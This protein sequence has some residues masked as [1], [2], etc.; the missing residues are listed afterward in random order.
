MTATGRCPHGGLDDYIIEV[1]P[2][3]NTVTFCEDIAAAVDHLLQEPV[4]QE[5]FTVQLAN[6]LGCQVRTKCGHLDGRVQT[7][8]WAEPG[9]PAPYTP[10]APTGA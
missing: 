8:C 4:Y 9:D 2:P 1:W 5:L 7:S 3:D 10:P 6:R